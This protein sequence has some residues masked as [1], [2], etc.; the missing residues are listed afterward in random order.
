MIETPDLLAAADV[1]Q[2]LTAEAEEMGAAAAIERLEALEA[3]TIQLNAAKA[4]LKIR[5]LRGLEQ[6]LAVG[7]RV[8]RKVPDIKKRFQHEK[9]LTAMRKLVTRADSNGEI[10]SGTDAA[11]ILTKMFEKTYLSPSTTAKTGGLKALGLTIDDVSLEEST[12]FKLD[13][14]EL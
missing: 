11:E 2:Q 8:Y 14:V 3:V 4:E 10:M 1:L 7:N 5:A 13:F 6:P 12:G 9:I